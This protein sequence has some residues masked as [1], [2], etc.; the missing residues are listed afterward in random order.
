MGGGGGI[1]A[2]RDH[3]GEESRRVGSLEHSVVQTE[4]IKITCAKKK[5]IIFSN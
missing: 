4:V 1:K 5:Y 2:V 3:L